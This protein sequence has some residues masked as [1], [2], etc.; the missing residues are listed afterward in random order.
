MDAKYP[1]LLRLLA[2]FSKSYERSW[3]L[4]ARGRTVEKGERGACTVLMDGEPASYRY[5]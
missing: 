2:L 4:Q 3:M 1:F 5:M